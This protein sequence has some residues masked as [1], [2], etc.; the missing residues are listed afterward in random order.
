MRGHCAC[1]NVGPMTIEQPLPASATGASE[2]VRAP[3]SLA[4]DL[5]SRTAAQIARLLSE[6]PDLMLPSPTPSAKSPP[7]PPGLAASAG[8][9]TAWIGGRLRWRRRWPMRQGSIRRP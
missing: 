9:C 4:D 1:R 2:R 6:R 7:E 5:R 3:R 8:H